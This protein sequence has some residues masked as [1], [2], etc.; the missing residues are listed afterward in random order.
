[1]EF[2]LKEF[3][4]SAE[5][6][7]RALASLYSLVGKSVDALILYFGEDPARCPYEHGNYYSAKYVNIFRGANETTGSAQ[8]ELCFQNSSSARW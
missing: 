8:F 4:C 3:L 6:E 2:A 5:S 7:A 1:M